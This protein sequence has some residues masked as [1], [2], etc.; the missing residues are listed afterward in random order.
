MCVEKEGKRLEPDFVS[1]KF[2]KIIRQNGL[3]PMNFHGLRHSC[4][5]LL[6]S[7]DF[8]IR[9]IQEYLGH[10][11]YQ[12]TAQTYAHVNFDNKRK[13]NDKISDALK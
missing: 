8:D 1:N 3:K 2:R 12:I 5:T 11:S 13:M 10:S 4:G 6:L 7:L 9:Y